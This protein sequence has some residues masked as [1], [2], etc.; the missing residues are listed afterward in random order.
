IH[1][2]KKNETL[3]ELTG[4]LNLLKR[5]IKDPLTN[6]KLQKIIHFLKTEDRVDEGWDQLLYHF[7]ELHPSFFDKLKNEHPSLTP[8]DLKLCAYLKMNLSTKEIANLM[9]VS[10][11]GIEASRYRLR[12]RLD[13][14]T[15]ANLNTFFMN[16]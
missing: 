8:K 4:Q 13:L 15:D 10:I 11:R 5:E 1:I 12:K 3:Q 6:K 14:P 7:N 2:A 9:N 16:Y